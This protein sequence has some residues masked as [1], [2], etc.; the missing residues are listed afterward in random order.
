MIA[1]SVERLVLAG[2]CLLAAAGTAAGQAREYPF[3][4]RSWHGLGPNARIVQYLGRE[5]LYLDNAEVYLDSLIMQDGVIDVDVSSTAP[6]SY[7]HVL[8]R[9][10]APGES[11]D[12]YLRLAISGS[13]AALQYSPVFR[14]IP[15]WQLQGGS[16]GWGRAVFDSHAWTHL[17]IDVSGATAK[18][19]VNGATEP[20]LTVARLRRPAAAGTVGLKGEFGAY[21]S[22][23]QL[24][25]RAPV[26]APPAEAPAPGVITRWELSPAL[27]T[28]SVLRDRLPVPATWSVAGADPDGL[29]NISRFRD[30]PWSTSVVLA[31][32]SIRSERAQVKKLF[33]G[34]SD[35]I[36]IYLNG[37]PIFEG[38]SGFRSRD[39]TFMG[40][41]GWN[42]AVYL[43]LHAGENVLLC[44]L[45]ESFGGW[46][47]QARFEDASG[48]GP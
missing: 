23:L 24:T 45:A 20:A 6:Q 21:F 40:M 30:K 34:Y 13:P 2:S 15:A 39:D 7:A 35:A 33:F 10:A 26:D 47:L 48:I 31:R 11:E 44:A 36:R 5:S 12:V 14:G 41:I 16:S 46:G 42:D 32:A 27:P 19:F 28:D 4:E 29:L 3:S 37:R 17:R 18:V 25:P 22:N 8:F 9:A 38:Q 1:S 43:D